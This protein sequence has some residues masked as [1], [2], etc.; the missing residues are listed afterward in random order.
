MMTQRAR[1]VVGSL[2]VLFSVMI[3]DSITWGQSPKEDYETLKQFYR[4]RAKEIGFAL[5]PNGKQR[6]KLESPVLT[7]T[8]LDYQGYRNTEAPNSGDVYVWTYHGRAIVAG[9][10][11]SLPLPNGHEVYQEFQALV[12]TPPQPISSRSDWGVMWSPPGVE[13]RAIPGAPNPVADSDTNALR[14]RGLQMRGLAKQFTAQTRSAKTGEIH[15]LKLLP[16]AVFRLDSDALKKSDSDVIDGALFIFT[17][18]LGT[19]P[20]L[21]LL[22]ECHQTSDGLRWKFAPGS[23][24]FQELWLKHRDREVWHLPNFLNHPGERN[25]VSTRLHQGITTDQMKEILDHD[26]E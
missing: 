25:F 13:L 10:V 23:L 17:N 7:W 16:N 15:P 26:P 24:A 12:E 5:D 6:L 22:I 18:Q 1:L 21:T 20:E 4:H 9:G 2:A 19:D 14:K 11:L 3:L 8:G